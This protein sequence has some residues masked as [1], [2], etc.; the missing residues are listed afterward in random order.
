MIQYTLEGAHVL[1]RLGGCITPQLPLGT[2][3]AAL[4]LHHSTTAG[5]ETEVSSHH[6]ALGTRHLSCTTPQL[7]G[8]RLKSQ[9]TTRH[10]HTT[11]HA[12][13]LGRFQH[14]RAAAA[15]AEV[16]GVLEARGNKE[17]VS[18]LRGGEHG[19]DNAG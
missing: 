17:T 3:H 19:V 6:S 12:Q 1:E 10:R 2:R 15:Q 9:A 11:I 13:G 18:G 5:R 16:A 7:P 4:V 8:G 14:E